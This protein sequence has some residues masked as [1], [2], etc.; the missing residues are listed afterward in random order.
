MAYKTIMGL[1]PTLEAT[2]LLGINIG[3]A[4]KGKGLVKTA[5]TNLMGIP[6]IGKTAS[7][8]AGL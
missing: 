4:R 7:M 6:L 2:E 8:I 1:V 3:F 5:A